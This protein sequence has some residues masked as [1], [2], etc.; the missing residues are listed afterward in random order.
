MLETI[1]AGCTR[2]CC[3][4]PW[5]VIFTAIIGTAGAM[6]YARRHFAIDTGPARSETNQRNCVSSFRQD[7]DEV[8]FVRLGLSRGR[9]RAGDQGNQQECC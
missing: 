3:R 5:L 6:E 9:G 8:V 7:V 4:F 1:I 2:A